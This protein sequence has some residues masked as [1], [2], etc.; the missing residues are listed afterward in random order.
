MPPAPVLICYDGSPGAGEAIAAAG[1]L[2]SERRAVVL[3]VGSL[4][5]VA[6]EYSALGS[7]AVDLEAEVRADAA[8]RAEAGAALARRAGFDADAR[9]MLE[10]P[11]WRGVVEFADDIDAAAIVLGTRGLAGLRALLESSF[12]HLV[13]THA[14][15]PVL[16][17]PP[18]P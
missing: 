12:S 3:D 18:L 11:T 14:G 9:S 16:V 17:V 8:A 5:L 4:E 13:A 10:A 2:L 7:D 6:Q 1:A 15:R